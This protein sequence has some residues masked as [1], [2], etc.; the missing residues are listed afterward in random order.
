MPW[1]EVAMTARCSIKRNVQL[2]GRSLKLRAAEKNLST[3]VTE[4]TT[5]SLKAFQYLYNCLLLLWATTV[6]PHLC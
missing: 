2:S 5:G 4:M 6:E 1:H 3:S